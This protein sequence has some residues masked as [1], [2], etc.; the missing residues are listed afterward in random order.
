MKT[1]LLLWLFMAMGLVH[2]FAQNRT[3][4]G[5]VTDAR[6][7]SP[8]P[9]VTVRIAKT[10]LGTLT[11]AR[12]EYTLTAPDNAPTLEFSFI[13]FD[14]RLV[15][16]EGR[17][18]ISVQLSANEKSLNEVVVV[19][20]GTVE[21]R[22]LT[23]SVSSI[24]GAAL[25]DLATPSVDR[26][27][28]GQVTGVQVNVSSGI[29]GQP[30]RIRIRGTN[31]IS[32]GS[33]P[34]YVV[35]GV[36]Y[37][38]GS[39]SSVTPNN[40]LGDINPNDIESMEVLKDGSATAIYGSR[41]ANGVILITTKKGKLGKPKV[42]YDAWFASA[43][44]SKRF[45]LL[46]ADEFITI[47][48]EKYSNANR[49]IQAAPTLDPSGKPYD[50]DWQ[51]M[52]L[53]TAFQHNHALSFSG[54][55][56]QTN[57]YFS[58]GYANLQGTTVGNDQTKYQFRAKLEQKA[59]NVLTFGFNGGISYVVNNGLNTGTNALSGNLANAIRALPNVPAQF[60]DGTYNLSST[61]TLGQGGNN[62]VIDDNYPNIKYVLDHNIYRN[63]NL[64]IVGDAFVDAQILKGLNFRSQIGIN[65]LNGEDY[66]YWNPV[67]GDGRSSNG[68]IYQ[69][70]LPIFRYNWFNTLSYN[71]TIGGSKINLVGGIEYQKTQNRSFNAQGSNLSGVY[72]AGDNIIS[73]TLATQQIGGNFTEQAFR[74]Y[75][76]RA[77]YAFLDRYLVAATFRR[78]AI[79]SLPWGK[80]QANLPGVS[81]GWR[82]SEEPFFKNTPALDFISNLKLRGGW[83]KVGNVEIGSYPYA[84]TFKP[85]PYGSYN[86]IAFGQIANPR[87]T[88]E[89]SKKYNV[90]IDAAFLDNRFTFTADYFRNDIDNLILAAPIPPSLGVPST[91]QPNILYLNAGKMHNKGF[92]FA[93]TSVNISTGDLTWTSSLNV[94]FVKNR[95]T[96]LY[97][98][99]DIIDAYNITRVGHSIGSFYG[100]E[101]AGVN[102]ANG[103]QLWVKA[104]GSIV[105]AD[106]RRSRYYTYDASKPADTSTRAAALTLTDKKILG[107]ANPTYYGGLNNTVTY[108]GFDLNI[109]LT[110]SGG[111]KVFNVTR[112]ESLNNQKFLNGSKELLNRWTTP[113]QATDVPVLVYNSDAF[114]LQTGN[115]NSR[116]L[117][118]GKFIRAQNIGLGYTLPDRLVQRMHISRLRV[119]A[120]VQNA[121]VITGYSGL[122]PELNNMTLNASNASN[123]R[124]VG[125]DYNTNPVPRTITFGINVGF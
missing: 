16:I 120:Q 49:A 86:G 83:A 74:S 80:Q 116:F 3:I 15:P 93:I 37:I 36:P 50:I 88:F 84:G 34:L 76:A 30:A 78:D 62:K 63:R 27:L 109:F 71:K 41:A 91:E 31:S 70:S 65:L 59:L 124:Q 58:V 20:Y 10:S 29:L 56:E 81:V 98:D 11:N 114:I 82:I 39:Q 79:S 87:L 52:V 57:Y 53:R 54:A 7:G 5:K 125:L 101:A 38:T 67:H 107:E 19:G 75:F 8:L 68:Y 94:T 46:N 6:D 99:A 23:G 13:G 118:D 85:V 92:E 89:T 117:E 95:V 18:S 47:A 22:D 115:V 4:S 51:D 14:T 43:T 108:K 123:N 69:Q 111:N 119:Y 104:D 97:N 113:G 24:K 35:D 121:F 100:F 45:D 9:G 26:Q 48:N 73:N 64:N 66:Q 106:P 2:A 110:F 42:T 77:N 122:D 44:P 60:A 103:N 96:Q 32:N 61:N 33:D 72:F 17:N 40:P 1:S 21:R 25:K 102:A 12:G 28:A 105:Q 55:T 112:Q 90:G